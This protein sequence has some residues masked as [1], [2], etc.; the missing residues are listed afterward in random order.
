MQNIPYKFI[1]KFKTLLRIFKSQTMNI[2]Y[3]ISL[4]YSRGII[5]LK[6]H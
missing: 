4:N 1:I 2:F 3:L 5:N 6:K